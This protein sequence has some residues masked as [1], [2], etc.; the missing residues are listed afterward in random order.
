MSF[1]Y[2]APPNPLKLKGGAGGLWIFVNESIL[3]LPFVLSKLQIEFIILLN[4][5]ISMGW[6]AG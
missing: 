3:S 6:R 4:R 5:N 2:D 1:F